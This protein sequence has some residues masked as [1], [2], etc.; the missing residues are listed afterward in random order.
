MELTAL[1]GGIRV[2]GAM[3]VVLLGCYAAAVLRPARFALVPAF[4]CVSLVA[5]LLRPLAEAGGVD[6]VETVTWSLSSALP[7]ATY[8][9]VVQLA[10]RVLPARRHAYVLAIPA[11]AIPLIHLASF[12]GEGA[13]ICGAGLGGFCLPIA[14]SMTVYEVVTGAAVL[15]LVMSTRGARIA[16]LRQAGGSR[17]RAYLMLAIMALQGLMLA[18]DLAGLSGLVAAPRAGLAAAVLQVTMIY[19]LGSALFRLPPE[20]ARARTPA[21]AA[22][23][24]AGAIDRAASALDDAEAALLARIQGLMTLDK[25]YQEPGFSR[26]QL[27]EELGVPEHRVT[28]AINDGLGQSFT[29]MVNAHRVDEA[30]DLLAQG[31]LSVTEIA[32]A[33][34][35]NSLATFNRV[36]KQ[37]TGMSPSAYRRREAGPLEGAAPSPGY[38]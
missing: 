27:A 14:P 26:R 5:A 33:V 18:L 32:F 8:L 20:Q 29:E 3:H 9:L 35:F 25:L 30:T 21:V 17:A 12:L 31:E 7:A 38:Q 34:G 4:Y 36:F 22:R 2:A 23:Q 6:G 13:A 24:T 28:R 11:L 1:D 15:L 37:K 19:L 10:D 16:A